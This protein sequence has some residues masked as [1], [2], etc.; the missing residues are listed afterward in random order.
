MAFKKPIPYIPWLS[1][2]FPDYPENSHHSIP[3]K[4]KKSTRTRLSS[5]A[6]HEGSCAVSG[7]YLE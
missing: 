1:R 4:H 7:F 6:Y 5:D 2:A 3:E